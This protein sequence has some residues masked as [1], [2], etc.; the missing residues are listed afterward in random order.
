[1]ALSLLPLSFFFPLIT[2]LCALAS[3][4]M[5]AADSFVYGGCSQFKYSS[6]SAYESGVNSLF[7]SLVN[8]ANSAPYNNFTM[9]GPTPEDTA[10]GLFQCRGDLSPSTC[11]SCVSHAVNQLSALCM[12]STGGALQLEGSPLFSLFFFGSASL[13]G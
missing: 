9:T 8:S 1:M 10:Y 5:S 7:T 4:A 13:Y 11:F 3:P 2:L 6:G 12:K